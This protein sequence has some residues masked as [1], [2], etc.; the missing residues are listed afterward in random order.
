MQTMITHAQKSPYRR[1][2]ISDVQKKRLNARP[3][4]LIAHQ[5][6]LIDL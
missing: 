3:R 2:Q 6:L 5:D 4:P 1:S